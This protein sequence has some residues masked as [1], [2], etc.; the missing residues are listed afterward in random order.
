MTLLDFIL[1]Y[2]QNF[3]TTDFEC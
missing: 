2:F 1:C 3:N